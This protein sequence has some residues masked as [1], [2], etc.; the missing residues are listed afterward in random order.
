MTR[1]A[2]L[3]TLGLVLACAV[4]PA[5][6]QLSASA[7]IMSDYRYRGI[8]LSG[9]AAAY[10]IA[11]NYDSAWGGYAGVALTKARMRYTEVDAQKLAYA[12]YAH[13][14]GPATSWDIGVTDTRYSG[15][16]RYNYCELHAGV[17]GERFSARIYT[18]AR[19]SGVGTRSVYAEINGSHPLSDSVDLVG[20]IGYLVKPEAR[21]DL[22]IG[23]SAALD[24]WTVQ[25]AW[26][27]ARE[28]APLYPALYTNRASR[29]V[30]SLTRGF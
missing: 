27:A 6:A 22:R 30:L 11:L 26:V 25:L 29:A 20:H 24:A 18:A 3:C 13:R 19:Y 2:R 14:L 16:D 28:E 17:S 23:L 9:A 21:A 12:G 5:L 4:S 7:S 10:N 1:A 15:S 8:S